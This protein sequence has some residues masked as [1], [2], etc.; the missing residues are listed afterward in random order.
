MKPEVPN[1]GVD[2]SRRSG[3]CP[4]GRLRRGRFGIRDST[5]TPVQSMPPA[6]PHLGSIWRNAARARSGP[7]RYPDE[8]IG[9]E[10][11]TLAASRSSS[12]D[13]TSPP[14]HD[15]PRETAEATILVGRRSK[16]PR[17]G[18]QDRIDRH[19][20]HAAPATA[21]H[22][23]DILAEEVVRRSPSWRC[24]LVGGV[25]EQECNALFEAAKR[26]RS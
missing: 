25:L 9:I 17:G 21:V 13:T 26:R 14:R 12:D 8:S 3:V 22:T 15:L 6:S 18:V 11:T 20:I 24:T 5:P 1:K 7:M 4:K 23:L 10:P 2:P 16:L 19:R